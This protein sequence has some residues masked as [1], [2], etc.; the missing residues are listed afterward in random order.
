MIAVAGNV[1]RERFV[2]ESYP[3]ELSLMVGDR[4]EDERCAQAAGVSFQWAA[5]WRAHA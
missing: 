5:E 2:G 4:A 3:A 1:L